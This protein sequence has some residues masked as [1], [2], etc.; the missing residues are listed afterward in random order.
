MGMTLMADRAK[1]P[2]ATEPAPAEPAASQKQKYD[3]P[4]KFRKEFKEKLDD[5]AA[6]LGVYP[7]ELV[8]QHLGDFI[9][10]EWTRILEEKLRR[11]K[12]ARPK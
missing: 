12:Q 4:V 8:E 11:A 9:H 6:D 3:A 10:T 1:K 2:T 7:G 5:V